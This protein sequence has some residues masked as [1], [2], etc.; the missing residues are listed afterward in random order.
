MPVPS[1]RT[2]KPV[3][4]GAVDLEDYLLFLTES[5]IAAGNVDEASL[6]STIRRRLEEYRGAVYT[7]AAG[8]GDAGALPLT[9]EVVEVYHYSEDVDWVKH[10]A[11]GWVDMLY[12]KHRG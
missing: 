1:A 3:F 5:M 6:P 8:A 9:R 11:N 12:D 7:G 4:D 10:T 2:P